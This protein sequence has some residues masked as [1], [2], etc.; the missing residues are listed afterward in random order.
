MGQFIAE[1]L[2][3]GD[4]PIVILED[5]EERPLSTSG[6]TESV[7]GGHDPARIQ[8]S[9]PNQEQLSRLAARFGPA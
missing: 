6:H 7:E 8:A 3:E 5:L 2:V 4:R 1:G 9:D